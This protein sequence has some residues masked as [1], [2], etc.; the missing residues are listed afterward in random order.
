MR[1]GLWIALL[2]MGCGSDMGLVYTEKSNGG[3]DDTA[4][5][6]VS[7][8]DFE[9]DEDSNNEEPYEDSNNEEPPEDG[10]EEEPPEDYEEDTIDES[11]EVD[12]EVIPEAPVDDCT[13]TSD[14]IYAVDKENS[15]RLYTFD[16]QSNSFEVVGRENTPI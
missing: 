16:P 13:E 12:D 2:W 1:Q 9:L 14:L 10:V 6:A 8:G 5:E 11:E 4:I 15:Q 7:E 3:E